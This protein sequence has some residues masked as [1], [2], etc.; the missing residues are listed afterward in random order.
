MLTDVIPETPSFYVYEG[1]TIWP[2]CTPDVTWIVYSNSV[3][4]DPS[5]YA[6]LASRISQKR[7]PLQKIAD[8]QVYFNE[9]EGAVNPAYAKK[10]G[11]IYMRC[12]KVIKEKEEVTAESKVKTGGLL[13]KVAKEM[14]Q[15]TKLK[16]SN[17]G[18]SV[19]EE[20]NRIGGVVGIFLLVFV[21]GITYYLFFT[22]KGQE[23][24]E[25][26]LRYLLFVPVTI[27][28]FLFQSS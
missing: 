22:T 17:S 13:E 18:F 9:G 16:I 1:T 6:K 11:K 12:R 3:S 27:H 24:T 2:N 23:I 4:M 8:R 28:T 15:D 19:L 26:A 5:D 21:T 14:A 7:R 25:A 10:D 20:Y